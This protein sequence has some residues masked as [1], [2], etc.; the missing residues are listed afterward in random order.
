V[1]DQAL[2]R[3]EGFIDVGPGKVWFQS[4]GKGEPLL[5]L[6]GGPGAT[7][8][9][10]V[11]LMDLAED[12]YQV[13]RYDQLGSGRSDRP[14][15]PSLWTVRRFTAELETIRQALGFPRMHLL[16]QSWGSFLALEYALNHQKRLQSLILFSGAASTRQCFDGMNALRAKLPDQVQ[17]TLARYEA[18]GD[19][20]NPEYVSGIEILLARHLCTAHPE[21]WEQDPAVFGLQVYQTMWGP[22]EF[23][24]TGTLLSWNRRDRLGEVKAPTLILCGRNDEVIPECSETMHAGIPDSELVIFEHSSPHAHHEEPERF[25]S[26]VRDFL[27]RNSTSP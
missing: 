24:C 11:E 26:V 19:T 4:I 3:T 20:T 25:F 15:D 2:Q 12:G 17:R 8:D 21:C 9:Y 23:T 18:A 22:N 6:H 27:S 5:I 10:L 16:G 7:S 1:L 14:D 13:V